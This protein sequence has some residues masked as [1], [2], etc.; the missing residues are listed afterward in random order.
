[1]SRKYQVE[2]KKDL[3]GDWR[4]HLKHSN[5]RILAASS[6]GFSNRPGAQRNFRRV[7]KAFGI[8]RFASTL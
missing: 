6:E 5:G 2:F 8:I 4:W 3:S 7:Q 1:M